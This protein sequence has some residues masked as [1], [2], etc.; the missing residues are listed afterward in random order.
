M[1]IEERRAGD[2]HDALVDGRIDRFRHVERP[3]RLA[4]HE[5]IDV[6]VQH[7]RGDGAGSAGGARV[8]RLDR[9]S[10]LVDGDEHATAARVGRALAAAF[11][12]LRGV[13]CRPGWTAAQEREGRDQCRV[14]RPTR[15]HHV[16]TLLERGDDRFGAHEAD[17]VV[18]ALEDV[19]AEGSG[20]RER[21]DLPGR[22][23]GT[24]GVLG[25]L[26]VDARHP[27]AKVVGAGDVVDD[28]RDPVDAGIGATGAGGTDD[29]RDAGR[30]ARGQH[31][32]EIC[33]DRF[34]RHFRGRGGEI[35]R[36]RVGRAAV[37]GDDIGAQ[38]DPAVDRGGG[39]SRAQH[40]RRD[41][42]TYRW[43]VHRTRRRIS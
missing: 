28:A 15:D 7:V 27:Q 23:R 40:S 13:P 21:R 34:G 22:E 19:E 41:E 20:G 42:H 17:D 18:A 43:R 38:R 25:L 36:S 3:G 39:E 32:S 6:L 29:H 35:R 4:H 37:D 10:R 14:G 12:D 5:W 8:E 33:G 2:P 26:A 30:G 16:G 1:V 31:Q 9:E 11:R 24:D